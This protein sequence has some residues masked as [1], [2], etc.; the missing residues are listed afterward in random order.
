MKGLR[1]R[2]ATTDRGAF[3]WQG[4]TS[5][6]A[7]VTLKRRCVRTEDVILTKAMLH[8]PFQR[9]QIDKIIDRARVKS[10]SALCD[11]DLIEIIGDKMVYQQM[12]RL[13]DSLAEVLKHACREGHTRRRVPGGYLE[14]GVLI[15]PASGEDSDG[16]DAIVEAWEHLLVHLKRDKPHGELRPAAE[17]TNEYAASYYT[18]E[19]D[20]TGTW[21]IIKNEFLDMLYDELV[22]HSQ[23]VLAFNAELA[24]KA[25]IR[26]PR[27]R[28]WL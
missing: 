23:A 1:R 7:N 18:E 2:S 21:R 28:I 5:I 11:E 6:S 27:I 17:H 22:D 4:A 9:G 14:S 15:F 25:F 3:W 13:P 16:L 10:V 26:R 24:E 8:T 19:D 20:G 12:K